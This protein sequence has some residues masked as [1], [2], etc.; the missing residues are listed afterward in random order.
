MYYIYIYIYIY[1]REKVR[2]P[3]DDGLVGRPLAQRGADIKSFTNIIIAIIIMFIIIII[4]SS[5]SSSFRSSSSSSSSTMI[6]SYLTTI[7]TTIII[8]IVTIPSTSKLGAQRAL[9]SKHSKR[10]QPAVC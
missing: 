9:T 1:G 6:I 7:I 5:S 4:S 8:V 10:T 3:G 2:Q